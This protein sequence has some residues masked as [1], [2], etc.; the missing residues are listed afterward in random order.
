MANDGTD[1]EACTITHAIKNKPA[2]CMNQF[3]I[4][5]NQQLIHEAVQ[6]TINSKLLPLHS[7]F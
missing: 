4:K 5:E 6:S 2:Y 1:P 7:K 3:Y